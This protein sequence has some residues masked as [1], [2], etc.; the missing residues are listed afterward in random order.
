MRSF[1]GL[2]LL[3]LLAACKDAP[4]PREVTGEQLLAYVDAQLAFGPRIPGSTGHRQMGRWLDSLLR[5]RA[6]TVLVDDWVHVTGR[7]DTLPLR[8]VLARFRPTETRRVL[9]VAHWDTRPRADAPT[10]SDTLAPV[11]GANDGASGV[12]VLLGVADALRAKAPSVGVDLLFVDGEDFGSFGDTTETLLGSR[13]FARRL[14]PGL[15]PE[16]AIV[17]DMVGARDQRFVQ[18]GWSL[19]AAPGLVERVWARAA[20]LGYADRFVAEPGDHVIDDHLPLQQAGIAA[21]NIIDL[22]YG[23]GGRDNRWHHTPEDT[24]DKLSGESLAAAAHVATALLRD[25]PGLR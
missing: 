4:P 14:P 23:P 17:W 2:L 22:N 6:D 7:G 11:P 19:T 8:N 16:F 12:A 21:I 5:A 10:S 13:R 1:F 20:A 15:P 24:R 18:E 9:Y 3:L 25:D